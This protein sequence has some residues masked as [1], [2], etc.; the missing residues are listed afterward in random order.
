[1]IKKLPRNPNLA[2]DGIRS[3]SVSILCMSRGSLPASVR[4][5]RYGFSISDNFHSIKTLTKM[6]C[7]CFTTLIDNETVTL[8]CLLLEIIRPS[9]PRNLASLDNLHNSFG[10][11]TSPCTLLLLSLVLRLTAHNSATP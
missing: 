3:S 10:S 4:L 6:N 9:L 7:V 8:Q 2:K 11:L 5:V 1:M